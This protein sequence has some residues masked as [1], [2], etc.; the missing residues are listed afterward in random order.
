MP[1]RRY[2]V[3]VHVAS[4]VNEAAVAGH[5][6]SRG[7]RCGRNNEASGVLRKIPRVRGPVCVQQGGQDYTFTCRE[8]SLQAEGSHVCTL[9]I[10]IVC[11]K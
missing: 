6:H 4:A 7:E 8:A 5:R 2:N 11:H 3:F 9:S 1:K 10:N